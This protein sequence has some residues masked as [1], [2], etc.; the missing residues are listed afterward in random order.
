MFTPAATT[1]VKKYKDGIRR[2]H[3]PVLVSAMPDTPTSG[4]DRTDHQDVTDRSVSAPPHRTGD[5][6]A[7]VP[8]LAWLSKLSNGW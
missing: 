8:T 3:V 6:A 2:R 4:R 1:T 7:T 5:R